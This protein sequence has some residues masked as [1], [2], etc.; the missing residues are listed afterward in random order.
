MPDHGNAAKIQVDVAGCECG[1]VIDGRR[2]VLQRA[3]PSTA[4]AANPAV[5]NMPHGI[6]AR[7]KIA[8]IADELDASDCA[9]AQAYS[10]IGKYFFMQK[11]LT[12]RSG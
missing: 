3:G 12:R 1:E 6:A 2:N 10:P 4:R 7:S 9:G 11:R 8:R 5:F